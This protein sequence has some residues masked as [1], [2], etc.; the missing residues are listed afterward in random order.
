M[1]KRGKL[2]DI[3]LLVK[4]LRVGLVVFGVDGHLNIEDFLGIPDV[5]F[6]ISRHAVQAFE[7][8]RV[9]AAVSPN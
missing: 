6:Q 1:E 8:P 9:D 7:Q 4:D 3:F 5:G 2:P